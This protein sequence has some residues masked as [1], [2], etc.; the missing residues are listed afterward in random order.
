[1]KRKI[2]KVVSVILTVVLLFSV[3]VTPVAA[4]QENGRGRRNVPTPEIRYL[5]AEVRVVAG[6][7]VLVA[8]FA[9]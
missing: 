8:V 7:P 2:S 5:D 9:G 6:Q 3:S 4:R 1:M